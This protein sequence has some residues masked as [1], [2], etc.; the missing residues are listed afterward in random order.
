MRTIK[1]FNTPILYLV[2]NRLNYVKKTFER[3]KEIKPQQLFI[4]SDGARNIKE[5]KVVN[6][7]RE[8]ILKNINWKCDVKTLFR[9]KNLGCKYA[10]S[11]AI[12]WF[13]ENIEQG[14]ILEDDCL[15]DPSFFTFC[16]EMLEMYKDKKEVMS[17]TGQN[18]LGELK[19]LKDKSYTFSKNFFCWGWAT[20]RESW[21][22]IDV[23]MQQYKECDKNK[24]YSL[25]L[26]NIIVGK[27]FNANAFT[28]PV[29]WAIDFSF[30]HRLNSGLC[31]VPKRNLVENIGLNGKLY[32]HTKPNYFDKRYLH[33]EAQELIA[34]NH[35]NK[36][37]QDMKFEKRYINQD[38]KRIILKKIFGEFALE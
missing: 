27:R 14:I 18:S 20:W 26:E 30:S 29:S 3:I 22:K 36:I 2:F 15:P 11:N 23:G 25:Y 19:Y 7:I 21:N 34:Y 6:E 4:A 1:Q 31:I 28:K 38:I 13:F 33:K 16:E 9:D 8:Y 37:K 32:T 5:K 12:N 17:I 10:V 24:L 35:P